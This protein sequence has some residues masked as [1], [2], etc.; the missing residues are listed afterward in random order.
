MSFLSDLEELKLEQ[1]ELEECGDLEERLA[2]A[3]RIASME[4]LK[5]PKW[6]ECGLCHGAGFHKEYDQS[7]PCPSCE[8]HYGN[9]VEK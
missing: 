1:E 7:W 4:Q 9:W 5:N 6:L 2:I 3:L 8:G